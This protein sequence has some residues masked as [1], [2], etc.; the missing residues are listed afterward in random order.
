MLYS[1]QEQI[2]RFAVE[3]ADESIQKKKNSE[4][5]ESFTLENIA[6]SISSIYD[7]E[8]EKALKD[9]SYKKNLHFAKLM[10]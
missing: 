4:Y 1:Y 2:D 10:N 9:L 7:V 3:L 6:R 5:K 8:Y